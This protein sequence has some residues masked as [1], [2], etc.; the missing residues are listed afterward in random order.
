[1]Q[2]KTRGSYYLS[3]GE[4]ALDLVDSVRVKK[5]KGKQLPFVL[6][7]FLSLTSKYFSTNTN[8]CVNKMDIILNWV[9]EIIILLRIV[10]SCVVFKN[11]GAAKIWKEGK[12][13]REESTKQRRKLQNAFFFSSLLLS[14]PSLSIL[15]SIRSKFQKTDPQI[16]NE[17]IFIN[18]TSRFSGKYTHTHTYTVTSIFYVKV[19]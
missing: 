8:V 13:R 12:A 6:S 16:K 14:S 17:T 9:L 18:L 7:F 2:N 11:G 15:F 10:E 1:M 5:Q 19:N 4:M 3:C